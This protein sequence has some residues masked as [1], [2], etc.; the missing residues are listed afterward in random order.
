[1]NVKFGCFLSSKSVFNA[2]I[3]GDSESE[4]SSEDDV[5]V[6]EAVLVPT[7]HREHTLPLRLKYFVERLL[8][9]F[10]EHQFQSHFRMSRTS[11]EVLLANLKPKLAKLE[12]SVGKNRIS[13]EKQILSALWLLATPDS[14]RYISIFR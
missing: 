4:E 2:I 10:S 3:L 7:S 9:G 5:E 6:I 8:P 13:A 14:F 1:M 12:G 11:Y